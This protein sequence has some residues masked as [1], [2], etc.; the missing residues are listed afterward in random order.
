MEAVVQVRD[1]CHS[2]GEGELEKPVLFDVA[3][4]MLPGEIVI[5]TGPSGSGKT[6]LL[7][8]IGGLRSV[9]HGSVR[10]LNQELNGATPTELARLRYQIGFIFQAHNLVEAL[11]AGQNVQMALQLDPSY[12]KERMRQRCGEMLSAVGLGDHV[13]S[14][15]NQLSGGQKQRVAIAR[16]LV[17]PP[18][19]VLADEPTASLDRVSGREIVDLLHKLAKEQGCAILLVTHDNRILDIA[20]R[21]LTLDDGRIASYGAG[22]AANAGYLLNAF[23]HLYRKGELRRHVT[24]LSDRQFMELLEAV[25]SE[26]SQ[27]LRTF[28]LANQE[29][30]NAVLDEILEAITLK[31]CNIV[32]AERA[33]LYLLEKES[34]SLRSKVAQHDGPGRLEI[35]LPLGKGIAGRVA[36]TGETLNVADP[37]S[38]PDFDREVD[39]RTGF[40]TCSI[41]CMPIL[42]RTKEVFAVA[43]LLNRMGGGPFT[44]SDERRF[45]HFAAPLG[46]VLESCVQLK[47]KPES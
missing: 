4:E 11:T 36:L 18:R 30:A 38:H 1:L 45:K 43:Q 21:I 10:V 37:Y 7:T 25:S 31:I 6:T 33:T 26:F 2:Y 12:S 9:Q 27:F 19:M 47:S 17:R 8:L 40:H 39:R 32:H 34:R 13:D 16:A 41:L 28:D 35:M 42:D 29:A 23:T 46:L 20:D 3:V 22:L 14:Y 24:K 5:V 44:A 15:P